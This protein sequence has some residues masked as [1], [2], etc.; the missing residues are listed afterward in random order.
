MDLPLNVHIYT[1]I[2]PDQV[3]KTLSDDGWSS[4]DIGP[5]RIQIPRG[6]LTRVQA[7]RD[8]ARMIVAQAEFWDK[9]L[10]VL[11]AEL[12]SAEQAATA[13][14][15]T[16]PIEIPAV[17]KSPADEP[18]GGDDPDLDAKVTRFMDAPETHR[19]DRKGGQ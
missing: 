3:R 12:V 14:P 16:G 5:L 18:V 17:V 9:D 11:E 1:Q 10:A 2:R 8:L 6:D 4:L 7:S 15:T 19:K 13:Q